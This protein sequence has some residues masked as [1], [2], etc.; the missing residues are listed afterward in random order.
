MLGIG[1]GVGR[2]WIVAVEQQR[3]LGQA[4]TYVNP[5]SCFRGFQVL[6]GG[7]PE[8]APNGGKRDVGRGPLWVTRRSRFN[9][10]GTFIFERSATEPMSKR[11]L[12]G[13][14]GASDHARCR[15]II[16]AWVI[17]AL[18]VSVLK[19]EATC[20]NYR[21]RQFLCTSIFNVLPMARILIRRGC[22]WSQPI[23]FVEFLPDRRSAN[24]LGVPVSPPPKINPLR[25]AG[26]P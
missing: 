11:E 7:V 15:G 23:C 14:P 25:T 3:Q 8:V 26:P 12:R 6:I 10:Q 20:A 5:A 24:F 22:R 4:M 19:S 16:K 9:R 18:V 21:H 17:Q 1:L 2:G 13:K